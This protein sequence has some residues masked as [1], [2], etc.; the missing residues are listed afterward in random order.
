M[1]NKFTLS[2]EEVNKALLLSPYSLSDSPVSWGLKA[3]EIKKYFYQFISFLCERLNLKLEELGEYVDS[4]LQRDMEL[5]EKK[6]NELSAHNLSQLSHQALFRDCGDKITALVNEFE[7]H[8]ADTLVHRDAIQRFLSIHNESP[9]CHVDIR[10]TLSELHTQLENA[11]SLAR[12]KSKV[13]PLVELID[14]LEYLEQNQPELGDVF[15]LEEKTVPDFTYF[16]ELDE[17]ETEQEIENG[18]IKIDYDTLALGKVELPLGTPVIIFNKKLVPHE[19][20]IDLSL[21]AR[22]TQLENL[23]NELSILSTSLEEGLEALATVIDT[24]EDKISYESPE[25]E[26][27]LKS[28][29]QYDLGVITQLAFMLPQER[30]GLESVINFQTGSDGCSFNQPEG[31]IMTGDDC[32]NGVLMPVANRVYEISIRYVLGT[33]VG[34]VCCFDHEVI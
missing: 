6:D 4:F 10:S 23:E 5:D 14:L 9:Y 24:K 11:L 7:E 27:E 26:F 16:G 18:A 12:G 21:L 30:V 13:V 32:L 17:Y 25:G 3:K 15:V 19:S 29:T 22:R 2:D 28:N 20:G 31:L 1:S 8:K 34:K 33:L